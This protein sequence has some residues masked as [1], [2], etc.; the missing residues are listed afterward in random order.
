ME[1]PVRN[2]AVIAALLGVGL[3]IVAAAPAAAQSNDSASMAAPSAI[4]LNVP[5]FLPNDT[6]A[7]A[8]DISTVGD[9]ASLDFSVDPD[10]ATPTTHTMG[11]KTVF[12][13]LVGGLVFCCSDTGF[14]VGVAVSGDP[15]SLK[16]VEI[17]GGFG[18]GR[19]GGDNFIYF[20]AD[21]IYL[22]HLQNHDIVP[23][24][25]AGLGITHTSFDGIGNTETGFSLEGGIQLPVRGPHVVRV[26]ISWVF[27]T[28]TVTNLTVSYS[29]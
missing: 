9:P 3:M 23:Y 24:V 26:Q 18:F 14:D 11:G 10:Q 28:L 19:L 6:Q 17:E 16:N 20:G 12:V 27:Q 13:R 5:S 4:F 25:G 15:K 22:F 7:P 29:F 1:V 21:G 8:F 2:K